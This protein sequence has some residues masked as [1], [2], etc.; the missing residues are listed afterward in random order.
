[1][2]QPSLNSPEDRIWIVTSNG[3]RQAG[4]MSL[5][6]AQSEAAKLRHRIQEAG[7]EGTVPPKIEVKQNILG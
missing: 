1:M 4:P 7:T 2:N 6:E 5:S 3:L